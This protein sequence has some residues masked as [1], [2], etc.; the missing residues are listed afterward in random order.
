MRGFSGKPLGLCILPISRATLFGACGNVAD[1]D[2][3]LR[4]GRSRVQIPMR[5]LNFLID[6]ILPAALWPWG[7]LDL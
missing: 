7:R 1:C 5:S 2:T 3:M 4:A 6:L